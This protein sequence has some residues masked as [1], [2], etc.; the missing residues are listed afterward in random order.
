[1][2]TH[3][4]LELYVEVHGPDDAPLTVVLAHC[5]TADTEN[6]R[7]Q[8]RDLL[9]RYGHGVCL[10]LW[11]HRG[12]GMSD[13]APQRTCT[14]EHLARDMGDVIDAFAPEGP[15]VLAGHSIGGMTMMGL[16]EQRPDI[17]ARVRGALFVATSSSDLDTVTLGLPDAGERLRADPPDARRARPR[18]LPSAPSPHSHH[19]ALGGAEVPLRPSPAP[20]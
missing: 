14:I 7:Y 18:Y 13:P 5:W 9:S 11:D 4:G 1:M 15:L 17:I 12:H 19:R 10:L 8:V 2:R 16:A 20:A 3:D 6:W